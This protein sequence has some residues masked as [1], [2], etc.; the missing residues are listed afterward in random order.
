MY[1]FK[2]NILAIFVRKMLDHNIIKRKLIAII[3][4]ITLAFIWGHS[5]V[6]RHTSADESGFF[7]KVLYP[8]L[9]LIFGKNGVTDH[10]VRKLAHFSEYFILGIELL[11]YQYIRY[12]DS[13]AAT[14]KTCGRVAGPLMTSDAASECTTASSAQNDSTI[15][16]IS[17]LLHCRALTSVRFAFYVAFIDETIQIFSGRGPQIADVWLDVF[18]AFCGTT[19]V[20]L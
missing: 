15:W 1:L 13:T 7:L 19:I 3:I 4:F 16:R 17:R 10:L 6:P 18:G 11:L 2:N 8:L 14:I 9:S 12:S 5:M 20:N